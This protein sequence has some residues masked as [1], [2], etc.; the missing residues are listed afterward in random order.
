MSDIQST[1]NVSVYNADGSAAVTTTTIGGKELLD[2]NASADPTQYALGTDYDATGDVVT[3]AA[4]A[5][6]FTFSG[7]GVIDFVAVTCATS[8]AWSIII[9]VD[10][11][12]K[13]RMSMSDLGSVIGLT[14]GVG[15]PIFVTTANKQFRWNP[16][17]NA[18]FTTGFSIKARATGANVTLTHLTLYRELV[19]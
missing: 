17:G 14:G 16:G 13:F 19:S 11:S 6:L 2:V 8:S 1:D 3:S 18:G 4:D 5:T 15:E 9:D 10:G 7:A 12:E